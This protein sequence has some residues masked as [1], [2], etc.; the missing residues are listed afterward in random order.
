[1]TVGNSAKCLS[2]ISQWQVLASPADV[3]G[4]HGGS[5][6][7]GKVEEAYWLGDVI[8]T[9]GIPF[10]WDEKQNGNWW[11][12]LLLFSQNHHKRSSLGGRR[13]W[14]RTNLD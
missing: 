8:P 11:G 1:M 13:R 10:I 7:V 12:V 6:S 2:A 5:L 4:D 14:I 3:M 9:P